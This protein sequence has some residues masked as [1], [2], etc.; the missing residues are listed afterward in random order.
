MKLEQSQ[1]FWSNFLLNISQC[2]FLIPRHSDYICMKSEC[3]TYNRYRY[4][5]SPSPIYKL[6]ISTIPG[7]EAH[8]RWWKFLYKE[9]IKILF[10]VVLFL[11][12][13]L[14]LNRYSKPTA[15]W[16]AGVWFPAKARDFSLF[17][18]IKTGCEAHPASCPIDTGGSFPWGKA[19]GSI[20]PLLDSSSWCGV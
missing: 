17:H 19:A 12:I 15:G 4:F 1:K 6:Q 20:P 11:Y 3:S 2:V 14:W 10:E 5:Y 7:H 9:Y 13:T 16:T 8:F 18:R